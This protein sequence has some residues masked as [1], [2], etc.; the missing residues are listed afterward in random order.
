MIETPQQTCLFPKLTPA[1]LGI[2]PKVLLVRGLLTDFYACQ[3]GDVG[4]C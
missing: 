2:L 4:A 1:D 3:L